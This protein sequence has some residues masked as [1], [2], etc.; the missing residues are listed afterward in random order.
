MEWREEGVLL[1]VRKHGENAAIIDVFT[2]AHGLHSGVVRG[3]AGRRMGPVLQPG[4]QLDLTWRARLEDHLGAFSVEPVKPRAAD[5]L[6][7]ALALAGLSAVCALLRFTLPDREPHPALYA[8]SVALLDGLTA[9][10]WP[11]VYLRW[12]LAL[13]DEMGF[14]LDLGRC[15][16][17]GRSDGLTFISPRTGR[18]VHAD[19]AGDWADRLLPL[20]D[21][22]RPASTGADQADILAGLQVTGYFLT[23]HLA[24]AQGDRP[25]PAARSRFVDLLAR[26]GRA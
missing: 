13:L 17:T 21:S 14:G 6:G 20:P 11:R 24:Q 4:A 25:I 23:Q 3:G 5:I 22:L 19:S 8:R 15:A 18:A 12:E 9:A 10:G 7:D 2:N 26:P 16:V 1:A